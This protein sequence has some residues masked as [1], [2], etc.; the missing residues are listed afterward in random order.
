MSLVLAKNG[1]S[2]IY[3]TEQAVLR[4]AVRASVCSTGSKALLRNYAPA[5]LW[6][7]L[8]PESGSNCLFGQRVHDLIAL[9][10]WM[11]TILRQFGA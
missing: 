1:K 7:S 2:W 10:G 5:M 4:S 9:G 6:A 11:E 3:D 8:S